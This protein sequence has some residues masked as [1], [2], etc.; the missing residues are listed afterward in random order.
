MN[1][2]DGD[3][4]SR[5]E[6]ASTSSFT[7]TLSLERPTISRQTRTS[8]L[9]SLTQVVNGRPFPGRR[10]SS[11]IALPLKSITRHR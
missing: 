6:M 10:I 4:M 9:D 2:T 7:Q 8:T 11:L 5:K 1:E 3:V